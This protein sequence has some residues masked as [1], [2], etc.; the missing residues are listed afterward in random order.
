MGQ[1][2]VYA[3]CWTELSAIID[4]AVVGYEGRNNTQNYMVD[5][6]IIHFNQ[7][8]RLAGQIR[9]QANLFKLLVI[10][11]PTIYTLIFLENPFSPVAS[12]VI[13]NISIYVKI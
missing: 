3:G 9:S 6:A 2:L 13:I 11:F 1:R 10:N 5:D 4:G 12:D 7:S 8:V